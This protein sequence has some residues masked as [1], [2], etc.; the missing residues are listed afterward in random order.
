MPLRLPRPANAPAHTTHVQTA[1]IAYIGYTAFRV[2]KMQTQLAAMNAH[3]DELMEEFDRKLNALEQRVEAKMEDME[4]RWTSRIEE[5]E[6]RVRGVKEKMRELQRL[7]QSINIDSETNVLQ[8]LDVAKEL[9]KL[10]QE[11]TSEPDEKEQP[12]E[13]NGAGNGSGPSSL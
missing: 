13:G 2:R 4:Q 6:E 5:L 7:I 1:Y 3:I 9:D 10:L 12:H 11:A 8:L